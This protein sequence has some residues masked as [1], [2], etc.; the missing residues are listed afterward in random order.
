L[1]FVIDHNVAATVR[2]VLT[3]AGHDCWS[4]ADARL[5]DAPDD[6]LA[7]YAADRNAALV[8][9]DI[10]FARRRR[11]NTAG[12]HVWLRCPEPDAA[13]VV[14]KHLLDLVDILA[15]MPDVVVEVR[16]STLNVW[17]PRWE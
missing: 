2:A 17:P 9:H 16:P 13:A 14:G 12:Q 3:Q 6:A 8:S 4:A 7:A 15:R 11:R 1:R 5:H 10:D